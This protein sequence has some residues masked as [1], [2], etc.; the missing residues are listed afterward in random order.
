MT[1]PPPGDPRRPLFLSLISTKILGVVSVAFG[2]VVLLA[3]GYLN[4][5]VR[6]RV[7]FKVMAVG[8]WVVPGAAFLV[9][10]IFL[11]ARRRWAVTLGLAT[12]VVQAVMAAGL[13]TTQFFLTPVSLVPVALTAV[14]LAALVQLA[15]HL[16]QSYAALRLVESEERPGFQPVLSAPRPVVPLDPDGGGHGQAV[17]G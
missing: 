4:P 14:W 1:T 7:Y 12:A 2:V 16:Y 11:K 9:A 17:V 3:F 8:V 5:L 6:F 10:W 15:L 13:L